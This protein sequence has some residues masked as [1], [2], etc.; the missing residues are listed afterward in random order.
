MIIDVL[1]RALLL[2]AIRDYA[3]LARDPASLIIQG[4]IT[5]ISTTTLSSGQ[6]RGATTII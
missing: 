6:W 3:L 5:V 4:N 1:G 2:M